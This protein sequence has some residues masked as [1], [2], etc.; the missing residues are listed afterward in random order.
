MVLPELAARL[1]CVEYKNWVKAGHCLL[2]LRGCLQGFVGREV[3]AFHRGLLAAAPGL[4]PRASCLSGSRCHPRA[5]QFQPQC[6]LC[7]EWKRE[8]LKHHTNGNG[9]VHWGNCRPGR[10]PFD[11]WEVAKAFMPR[12]LTDKTGP[13][14][15]DAAALLSLINSCDHFIV[16]RKKVTE[17]IRCRNEIMHSTEMKVSSVWLREFQ[18]KIQNFLN[19]FKNIPEI[20]A[21]YSRIEQLL[22]SDWAVLMPE[23]DLPD[24][25]ANE[26]EI[27]LSEKQVNEIEIELLQEKL[28]ELYLQAIEQEALPE[29][30]LNRLEGV[31]E[32]LRNNEDLSHGV[33]ENLQKLTDLCKP[34]SEAS[35][36]ELG[37]GFNAQPGTC[38]FLCE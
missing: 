16:D 35:C 17:V 10:W 38:V 3:L 27:C 4:G 1:N 2:L 22:S 7:T 9:D 25:L 23:E 21:V 36:G 19:E 20:V 11:A 6:P 37:P 30:I 5:R 26:T 15:C 14:D 18:M 34:M 8:I 33:A 28:Q 24:G 29:E 12:G 31:R 13:E 32:F